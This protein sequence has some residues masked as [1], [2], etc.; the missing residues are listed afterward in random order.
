MD[1]ATPPVE[2]DHTVVDVPRAIYGF[3]KII[4]FVFG[5]WGFLS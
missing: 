4:V 3:V 1:P 5:N 2:L